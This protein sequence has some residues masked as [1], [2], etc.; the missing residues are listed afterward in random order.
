MLAERVN[1]ALRTFS[2]AVG[3]AV[4]GEVESVGAVVVNVAYGHLVEY[5]KIAADASYVASGL[6]SA[7]DVHARV[8]GYAAP[9]E[10]LQA[11]AYVGILLHHGH[12]ETFFGEY[13][14]GE[15]SAQA[16][17]YNQYY[18]HWL[19]CFICR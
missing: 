11:S 1:I 9:A 2:Y 6:H 12:S 4:F 14:A 15:E 5:A 19:H 10:C 17:A 7:N 18:L 16:S 8:E 3:A 13:R